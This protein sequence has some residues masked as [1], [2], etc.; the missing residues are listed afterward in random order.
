MEKPL[1][2]ARRRIEAALVAA[3]RV[4]AE[5][6][7]ESWAGEHGYA[8]VVNDVLDPTLEAIGREWALGRPLVLAQAYLAAKLTERAL[9]NLAAERGS[10]PTEASR[11]APVVIGNIEDDYHALG[12][13]MVTIFLEAAGWTVHDLGNDVPADAFVGR[14]RETG[15][16]VIGASAMMFTTAQNIR[17][18]RAAIDA[19]GLTGRVQLAVGGAVFTL[20][21][22]LVT[23]VGG[24]GTARN[25]M[26]VPALM[27]ELERAALAHGELP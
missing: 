25:A 13:R 5:K 17:S 4:T 10:A 7:I 27:T 15:A 9:R 12:R 23:E 14:A 8:S 6:V 20:R 11:H 19:A 24:D 26:A 21:P 16:R 2:E 3:D 18:L 1:D 22:E